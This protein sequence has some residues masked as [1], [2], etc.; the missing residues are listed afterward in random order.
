[1]A[2][3][4]VGMGQKCSGIER[5][6]NGSGMRCSEK[7]RQRTAQGRDDLVTKR[8]G[9][10]MLGRIRYGVEMHRIGKAK[11]GDGLLGRCKESDGKA[12]P[13]NAR[14]T[15]RR[16]WAREW[17]GLAMSRKAKEGQS[18]ALQ[19]VGMAVD[20]S[21]RARDWNAVAQRRYGRATDR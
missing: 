13:S 19:R 10:V 7:Q 15:E 17:R 11:H 16:A 5:V 21:V 3:L 20:S 8:N 14:A 2:E 12:R 1:M 18:V 6:S 4:G 9:I